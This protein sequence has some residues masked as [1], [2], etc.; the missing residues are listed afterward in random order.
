VRSEKEMR[1]M[2]AT[3]LESIREGYLPEIQ[4]C[5]VKLR[6]NPGNADIRRRIAVI[7]LNVELDSGAIGALQWVLT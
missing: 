4:D 5:L 7:L 2:I 3:N 1:E 6:E